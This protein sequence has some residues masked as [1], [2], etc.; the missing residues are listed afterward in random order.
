[1]W[2]FLHDGAPADAQR[3]P[4]LRPGL[5]SGRR[6]TGKTQLL[7]AVCEAVGGLYTVCVQDEGDLA[8]RRRFAAT[9]TEHAGLKGAIRGEPESWERLIRAALETAARVA[10]AGNPPAGRHRRIPYVMFPYVMA[11]APQLPSLI[12]HLY[13]NS[14]QGHGPGG[15]LI[16][17]GSALSVMSTL[18]SGTKPPSCGGSRIPRSRSEC[19]PASAAFPD[20]GP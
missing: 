8:A 4:A 3:S 16:L 13:D 11:N 14:Q 17:C 18:L 9:I 5:V 12:Q 6:R 19:M 1:M 2:R 20:I 7:T 15:R 10:P